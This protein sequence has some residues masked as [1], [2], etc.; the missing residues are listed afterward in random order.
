M[1]FRVPKEGEDLSQRCA[2]LARVELA[3]MRPEVGYG[4]DSRRVGGEDSDL[5]EW[6]KIEMVLCQADGRHE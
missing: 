5:L 4:L 6:C 1:D 3:S 2:K